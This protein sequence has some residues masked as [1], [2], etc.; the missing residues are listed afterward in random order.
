MTFIPVLCSINITMWCRLLLSN[1][2]NAKGLKSPC[3]VQAGIYTLTYNQDK[4]GGVRTVTL[5]PSK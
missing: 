5:P 4:Q 1:A 3:R 2:G